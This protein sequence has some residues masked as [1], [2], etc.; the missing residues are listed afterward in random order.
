MKL[1]TRLRRM[2]GALAEVIHDADIVQKA[3]D[4]IREERKEFGPV[5]NTEG[6][7]TLREHVRVTT[8]YMADSLGIDMNRVSPKFTV[9]LRLYYEA[10][11][12]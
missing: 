7:E 3:M 4:F 2:A 12:D 9:D 8:R 1:E 5:S 10:D 6:S 11:D